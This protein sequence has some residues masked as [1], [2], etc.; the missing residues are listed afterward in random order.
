MKNSNSDRA[1]LETITLDPV[2]IPLKDGTRLAATIHMPK[3][4]E[5]EPVPVILEYLPYR[6]RDGTVQRDAITHPWFAAQGYAAVR[7]DIRGT[8]DS[9]GLMRDEYLQQE[10]DDAVEAIEWLAKQKWCNGR[11]G[12]MGISWGGFN[13]LQIAA[14]R[15]PA[16]K[17]IITLCSTDDRF[18]D[19]AHW[20]GGALINNTMGWG[21]SF[22]QYLSQPPDP[23][24]VGEK[25]REM[26]LD[27]LENL[28]LPIAEWLEHQHYDAYW[29][30]GSVK[31]DYGAIQA[32][33]YAMG[34]WADG[35]SNAV[36]RMMRNLTCPKK[37]LIG[38]WA[39]KYPHI[40]TPK[41]DMDFLG[42]AL[43][44][45]DHWLKD[46][47]TGI[48]REPEMQ[49]WLQDS[50]RPSAVQPERPGRWVAFP[51]WPHDSVQLRAWHLGA[52]GLSD[53][54]Q[55]DLTQVID[56]P[57]ETGITFGEWCAYSGSGELP[58][59]QRTDDG[60]SVVFETE[61]LSEPVAIVGAP[62]FD[63]NVTLDDETALL[64]GRLQDVHP[65]GASLNVSYGLLNVS[66]RNGS[67]DPKPF[68]AKGTET[69]RLLLNDIAHVFPAGHRI[70]IAVS[71]NFWP[72]A[73]PA[74]RRVAVTLHTGKSRLTL[75]VLAKGAKLPAPQSFGPAVAPDPH[76]VA[77]KTEGARV[78]TTTENPATREFVVTVDRAKSE[79]RVLATGTDLMHKTGEVF[80]L[81]AGQPNSAR[82]EVLSDWSLSRGKD[83][84]IRTKS[85]LTLASTEKTFE[86]SA[87]MEAYEDEALIKTRNFA[88]SIPR[89]LV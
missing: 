23:A 51:Q 40:A 13:G 37:G 64:A 61:P 33:V 81:T 45:W 70:R 85:H 18:A 12:M 75:P 68:P 86:L 35:Y 9:D 83:W 69:V 46:K 77:V 47:D 55:P 80:S 41:P 50:V 7:L 48:M 26:W 89:R 66:Q 59:D 67:A 4:S 1:V 54:T 38:P 60:R 52:D 87:S 78:R 2:W 43:R 34:G 57:L 22:F 16:L 14:R 53:G 8:G 29:R 62:L 32:A 30:H 76:A 82:M 21:T 19:D 11:V 31:E 20:M 17:A 25:W 63:L 44:W 74:P 73:W 49:V 79:Y 36:P 15:P 6:R 56:S 88:F 72:L 28:Q 84:N 24:I 27:R 10:Q 3:N 65:D 42:E 58:G 39:H 5:T 71:T